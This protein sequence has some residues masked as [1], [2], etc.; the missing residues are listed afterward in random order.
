MLVYEEGFTDYRAELASLGQKLILKCYLEGNM[1]GPIELAILVPTTIYN[2]FACW[3]EDRVDPPGDRINIGNHALHLQTLGKVEL[4]QPTIVLDHSLGGVEGYLLINELAKLGRVCIYDRAG[5]GWSDPGT[6]PCQSTYIVDELDRLLTAAEIDP[7]YLLVGDSFGTFNQRLYA[8]RYPEKVIGLVL[9]DGLHESGMLA[10]PWPL[11][12][13]KLLFASGFIVAIL[14]ASLGIIRVISAIGLFEILRPSLR[15]FPKENLD[16]VK[17]S[18]CRP[19]HWWTMAQEIWGL[20]RSAQQISVAQDL[21]DLPI[22][23]IKA[24]HFFAPSIVTF[25][26][27]IRMMDRLRDK[28]HDSLGKLSSD[29]TQVP[30][31]GSD[32]FVWVEEP[33]IIIRA[34]TEML[35]KY[36]GEK[37][38][39]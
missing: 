33:E 12:L 20:D 2:L 27:P 5:Y 32:H 21:G 10:M 18:F 7:P 13:V 8:H 26:L 4:N 1:L 25:L 3:Q 31:E 35:A 24:K 28:M 9:T 11:R 16:A 38:T 22:I 39:G 15:K 6:Q 30:A 36:A 37:T 14:G 29:V 17:R 34:V 23:S 19:K